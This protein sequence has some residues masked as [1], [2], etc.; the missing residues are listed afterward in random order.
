MP[1][2]L[3][4][5]WKGRVGIVSADE[6]GRQSLTQAG[7]LYTLSDVRRVGP[8]VLVGITASE[9]VARREGETPRLY[10]AG[11]HYYLM[12][13]NGEWVVVASDEWVT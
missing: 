13:R 6:W 8:F 10:A 1:A 4:E 11:I 5:K 9:R 2:A 3:Q 7:V 12:E